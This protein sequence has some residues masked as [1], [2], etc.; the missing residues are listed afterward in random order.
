MYE[1][2]LIF[3][4]DRK[5]SAMR[6]LERARKLP[7]GSRSEQIFARSR[8]FPSLCQSLLQEIRQ[9]KLFTTLG[10]VHSD[11]APCGPLH[12]KESVKG[13]GHPGQLQNA[14]ARRVSNVA[15]HDHIK[16]QDSNACS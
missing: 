13:A 12:S 6:G 4:R 14:A 10:R 1:A 15:K 3:R 11:C 9:R 5:A 7:P 2:S 8:V 16:F